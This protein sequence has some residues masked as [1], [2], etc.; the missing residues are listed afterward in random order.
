[1]NTNTPRAA[2]FWNLEELRQIILILSEL[3]TAAALG[4]K[5]P[6]APVPARRDGATRSP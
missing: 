1:M 6:A 4:L 3:R 5:L 2:G